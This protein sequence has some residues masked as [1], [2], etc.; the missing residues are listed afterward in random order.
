[1]LYALC[2]LI[3]ILVELNALGFRLPYDHRWHLDGAPLSFF[4]VDFVCDD[5]IA[6]SDEPLCVYPGRGGCGSVRLNTPLT[7]VERPGYPHV[8]A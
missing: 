8:S 3:L 6:S 1:M 7:R 2:A 4:S 5:G